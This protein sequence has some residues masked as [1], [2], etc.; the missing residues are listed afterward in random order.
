[1]VLKQILSTGIVGMIHFHDVFKFPP[2]AI[3]EP[4]SRPG[5]FPD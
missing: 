2:P 1:M 4:Y 5:I 3:R